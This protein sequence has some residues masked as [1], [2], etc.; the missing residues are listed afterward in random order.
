MSKKSSNKSEKQVQKTTEA[1]KKEKAKL[2]QV[3]EK[4]QKL[5]NLQY[6]RD[7]K[8]RGE[9]MKMIDE[10]VLIEGLVLEKTGGHDLSVRYKG[11]QI[12]KICPLSKAWSASIYGSNIQRYTVEHVLE[13]VRQVV[14]DSSS[15][16]STADSEMIKKLEDRIRKMYRGTE[17]EAFT[18]RTIT[19]VDDLV[20]EI[21]T[22]RHRGWCVDDEEYEE[23]LCCVSTRFETIELRCSVKSVHPAVPRSLPGKV[24]KRS[25]LTL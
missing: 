5:A 4:Y 6:V 24:S 23:G 14:S 18:D 22:M 25:P 1:P 11:R 9:L 7:D 19:S 10:L 12:V 3:P 2:P 16:T 21:E 15:N 8:A 20:T 17:L 13:I